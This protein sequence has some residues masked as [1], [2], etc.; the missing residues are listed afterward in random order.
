MNIGRS[1]TICG[2]MGAAALVAIVI[3][4]KNPG[5]IMDVPAIVCTVIWFW[6]K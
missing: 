6:R 2:I 3:P 5:L 4:C 1:I